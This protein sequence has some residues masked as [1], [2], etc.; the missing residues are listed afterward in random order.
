MFVYI[1]KQTEIESRM[2]SDEK[3]DCECTPPQAKPSPAA[4][5]D[6]SVRGAGKAG[7][8]GEQQSEK[9]ICCRIFVEEACKIA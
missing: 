2:N 8:A 1:R 4:R 9:R 3:Q 5:A 7:D 6:R